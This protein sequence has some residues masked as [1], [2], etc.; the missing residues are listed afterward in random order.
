MLS[1]IEP[2][3]IEGLE[4]YRC[5]CFLSIFKEFWG[6]EDENNAENGGGYWGNYAERGVVLDVG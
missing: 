2:Y 3:F 5:M 1:L 4:V 6:E